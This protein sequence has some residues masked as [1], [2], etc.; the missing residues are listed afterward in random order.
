MILELMGIGALGVAGYGFYRAWNKKIATDNGTVLMGSTS[1]DPMTVAT[2]AASITTRSPIKKTTSPYRDSRADVKKKAEEKKRQEEETRRNDDSG[3]GDV[4][5]GAAIG[6]V[7]GSL[8]SDGSTSGSSSI[9]T[10]SDSYGG[11]S[12]GGAGYSSSWGDDSSSSSSS[13]DSGSSSSFDSGGG[14]GGDY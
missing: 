9:D 12:S 3:I 6:S 11:G 4:L 13:Y 8:S 14:G 1:G 10:G 2:T 5:L 7:I